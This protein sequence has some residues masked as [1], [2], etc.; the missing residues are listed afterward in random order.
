MSYIHG[1]LLLMVGV[2]AMFS[3]GCTSAYVGPRAGVA[4]T[5]EGGEQTGSVTSSSNGLGFTYGITAG[6]GF[7]DRLGLQIDPN[8]HTA[9]VSQS[10]VYTTRQNGE[11]Y[12]VNATA[13]TFATLV[14]LPLMF[15]ARKVVNDD[16]RTMFGIGGHMGFR[17]RLNGEITSSA[18]GVSAAV[19]GQEVHVPTT[20]VSAGSDDSIIMGITAMAAGDV[21]LSEQWSLRGS[22][23]IQHDFMTDIMSAYSFGGSSGPL[24]STEYPLTRLM[25]T[26]SLL[27][28]S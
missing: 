25:F 12:I 13:H 7:T 15:T 2:S 1:I 11:D 21:V 10:V 5:L 3:T 9:S 14:E 19:E 17:T 8:I 24:I 22:L 28:G 26:V 16:L 20:S 4:V 27:F 18:V 23:M 6:A